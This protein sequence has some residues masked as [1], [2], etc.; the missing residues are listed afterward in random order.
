[1]NEWTTVPPTTEA[2]LVVFRLGSDSDLHAEAFKSKDFIATRGGPRRLAGPGGE[3]GAR[4]CQE[5]DSKS[6]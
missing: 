1:M 4:D 6:S 5:L 2:Y 3:E